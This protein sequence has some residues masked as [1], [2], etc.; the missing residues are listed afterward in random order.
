MDSK[1]SIIAKHK[2]ALTESGPFSQN[3]RKFTYGSS[4]ATPPAKKPH[5]QKVPE[6]S[7]SS[8]NPSSTQNGSS[9]TTNDIQ[10]QRQQ[11]PVFAVREQ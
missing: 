6:R 7:N 8:T 5:I 2:T 10:T 3:K 11:L 1:Y 4:N 9:N